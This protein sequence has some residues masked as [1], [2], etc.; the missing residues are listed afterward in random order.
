MR[1]EQGKL[2]EMLQTEQ[3]RVADIMA[4]F[5]G[6][7]S[8]K[9]AV[10]RE[11]SQQ[12]AQ[13]Q[14]EIEFLRAELDAKGAQLQDWAAQLRSMEDSKEQARLEA[15]SSSMSLQAV[16]SKKASL[17]DQFAELQLQQERMH[18]VVD[19][20]RARLVEK[21]VGRV[22]MALAARAFERWLAV[23]ARLRDRTARLR[24]AATKWCFATVW[25]GLVAWRRLVTTR[26][27]LRKC[28]CRLEHVQLT[29]SVSSWAITL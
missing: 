17:D 18:A 25:R 6:A 16:T 14:T 3:E 29:A 19:G 20:Y 8:D 12:I 5:Q 21:C 9:A 4:Q 13:Q 1:S 23:G 28:L 22:R 2:E 11:M 10:A 26:R 24:A 15:E 27:A 7:E